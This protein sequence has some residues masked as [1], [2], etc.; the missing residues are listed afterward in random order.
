MS[1]RPYRETFDDGP[2]GWVRVVDNILPPTELPIRESA[3]WSF[4]PWWLDYNHAPPGGGYLQLLACLNTQGP[5]GE[6][7]KE[8]GGVNRFIA[9]KHSRNLLGATITVRIKGELESAG[10]GVCL[11]VQAARDGIV[12]GWVC[13]GQPLNV[14]GA[15]TESSVQIA[16]DEAGWTCLGARHDRGDYYGRAP[17]ADVLYNVNINIYLVMFPVNPRPLGPLEGAPHLLRAGRDYP[18]WPSSV[19]QG[20]VAID[21][22]RIEYPHARRIR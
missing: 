12:T 18:V 22:F 20:Y 15:Y 4:G 11:L 17:L 21:E 5:F 16:A 9:G 14:A 19:A 1:D 10:A 6:R 3:A 2:G 7:L 13:S 8:V